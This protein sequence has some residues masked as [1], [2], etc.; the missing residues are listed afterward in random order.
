MSKYK[1]RVERGEGVW[2]VDR[3]RD[4]RITEKVV[5]NELGKEVGEGRTRTGEEERGEGGDIRAET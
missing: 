2:G 5:E 1:A 3:K 4:I